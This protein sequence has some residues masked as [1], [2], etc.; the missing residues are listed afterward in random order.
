[1]ILVVNLKASSLS[2]SANL[3]REAIT[4][5]EYDICDSDHDDRFGRVAGGAPQ[6][7]HL[8]AFPGMMPYP[9]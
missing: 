3:K 5:S 2:S 6:P 8:G 4:Q 9:S 1:M 7:L